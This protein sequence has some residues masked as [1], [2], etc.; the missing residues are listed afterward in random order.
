MNRAICGLLASAVIL[1]AAGRVARA[2]K[3][4]K[5]VIEQFSGTAA[6]KFK[7]IVVSE[8]GKQGIEV[9]SDK[10]RASTEAELGLLNVSDNYPAVA[11]ELGAGAFIDGTVTG[12]KHLTA[13]LKVKGADGAS[14]GGAS[15][16]GANE[17]KL[18][19]AVDG[20][21]G[22]KLAA[23]FGGGAA[24]EEAAAPVAE[25][26][27]AKEA[28]AEET[29]APKKKSR[30][31]KPAE[32][33]A[34]AAP[35]KADGAESTVAESAEPPAPPSRLPALDVAVGAHVYGR[36]FTYNQSRAGGQQAYHLPAVPAPNVSIDYFFLP[37]L[38][39]TVGAEYSVALISEDKDH[40]RYRTA[41][42]AYSVGAKGRFAIGSSSEIVP[43]IAYA[44]NSF[45]ITPES[46]DTS[47]PQVAAVDY[48]QVR[49]G[50][51]VRLGLS[52]SLAIIGGG[53]YLHLLGMGEL[54]D[55]YFPYA[56]GRGGEGFAGVAFS[57]PWAAGLEGRL[58]ADLR[59]YAFSMNSAMEDLKNTGRIAGGA[60][61][62]YVGA[63]LSLA[64]RR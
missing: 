40:N 7:R 8:L 12:S 21:L 32:E 41:S 3:P 51:A 57:L 43:T 63:N 2:D 30:K 61:D 45:K 27:P 24:K 23:I 1:C 35:A 29:S 55:V 13:R 46:D 36:N 10:K 9:V 20:S 42:M 18:L 52:S 44:S 6:E 34:A 28:V 39:L 62:Q 50:A 56:T 60:V 15:W 17:R 22:K 37:Y 49:V 11:K 25:E 16:T 33:E 48:K 38:G 54:H 58:T 4:K 26:A 64:L 47:P 53:N 59:R 14:L 5:V 19:G 31:A